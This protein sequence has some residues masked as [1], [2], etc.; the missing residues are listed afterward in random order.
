MTGPQPSDSSTVAWKIHPQHRPFGSVA[1]PHG[2]K[3]SPYLLAS[4][5]HLIVLNELATRMMHSAIGGAQHHVQDDEDDNGAETAATEL[6][7]TETSE[8]TT[9]RTL[10][11]QPLVIRHCNIRARGPP[12]AGLPLSPPR[13]APPGVD[14]V[15]NPAPRTPRFRTADRKD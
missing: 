15:T 5:S 6:P 1:S 9:S 8:Q 12:C 7:G 2:S 14:A 11:E 10:H 4:M 3:V 13:S